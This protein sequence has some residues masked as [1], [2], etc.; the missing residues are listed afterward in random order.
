VMMFVAKLAEL[1]ISVAELRD[2]QYRAAQGAA[3]RAAAE[4]LYAATC[5][6][7]AHARSANMG[8][9]VRLHCWMRTAADLARLDLASGSNSSWATPSGSLLQNRSMHPDCAAV[10]RDKTQGPGP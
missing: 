4:R 8:P 2:A 3:A 9:T 1:A 5:T 10:S 6:G 7:R